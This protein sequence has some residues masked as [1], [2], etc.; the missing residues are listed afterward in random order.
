MTGGRRALAAALA[1]ALVTALAG[2]GGS[3]VKEPPRASAPLR[4]DLPP[5]LQPVA[6]ERPGA[7]TL[8]IK[9]ADVLVQS[10]HPLPASLLARAKRMKHVVATEQFS[11][12]TF[13]REEQ[14]VTYAAVNPATF[15]RFTPGPTATLQAVWDRIADGEIALS[16]DL[17]SSLAL[18]GDYIDLGNDQ[19]SLRAHI[20]AYAPLV[21]RSQIGALINERWAA[22]LGMPEGNALLLSTGKHTPNDVVK[23]LRKLVGKTGSVQSLALGFDTS[24]LNAAVLT[25]GSVSQAVGSFTYTANKNGTVNP[26]PAWISQYIRTEEVPI[27]GAVTCNKAMIPQLRMAL[28]EVVKTG[29]AKEIHASE[30]GGCYVPRYIANNPAQGLSFHTWGTAIDLNVPGNERGTVGQMN[31]TVVSIFARCGFNWGGYWHYTDPMHFEMARLVRS[32]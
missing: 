28:N 5:S 21:V 18:Q 32:C 25:G 8:K 27:I 1:A 23:R 10:Q 16:P 20:G 29:L 9:S 30:Y 13:Y 14:A 4:S 17:K 26:D 15:R 6:M 31:R 7:F 3:A 11:L 2:C 12:A 19:G 24:T 22:R